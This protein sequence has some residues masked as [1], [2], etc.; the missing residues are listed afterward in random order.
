MF[1]KVNSNEVNSHKKLAGAQMK[2]NFGVKPLP[3]PKGPI[4]SR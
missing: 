1:G 2:G 3:A 4:T